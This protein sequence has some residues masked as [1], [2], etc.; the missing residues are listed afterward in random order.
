MKLPRIDVVR[1]KSRAIEEAKN[2]TLK[3]EDIEQVEAACNAI[4]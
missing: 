3:E 4:N 2:F 1:K